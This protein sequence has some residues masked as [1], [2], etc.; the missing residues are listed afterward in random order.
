MH[1][2]GQGY[3]SETV[4]SCSRKAVNP[5]VGSLSLCRTMLNGLSSRGREPPMLTS[6]PSAT[7]R[8]TM[9]D[10]RQDTPYPASTVRRMVSEFAS[11]SAICS[12][13]RRGAILESSTSRV[14]EQRSRTSQSAPRKASL[15]AAP[16][17]ARGCSGPATTSTRHPS[18]V[19]QENHPRNRN[20]R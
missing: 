1:F 11:S 14:P 4:R 10:D 18:S 19:P 15:V 13:P 9:L 12:G 2:P 16:A 8:P 17:F 7:S 20:P 5:R 6:A 3:S